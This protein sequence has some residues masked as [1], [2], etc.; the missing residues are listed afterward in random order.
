MRVNL[1]KL[2]TQYKLVSTLEYRLLS[3]WTLNKLHDGGLTNKYFDGVDAIIIPAGSTFYISKI[4][5]SDHY[6]TV[7]I[8][9]KD[10]DGKSIPMVSGAGQNINILYQLDYEEV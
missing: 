6:H 4:H 9:F 7:S 5:W 2:R 8:H 3:E 1:P 10:M